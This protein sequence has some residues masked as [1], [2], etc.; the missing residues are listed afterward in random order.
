MT[1]S[2]VQVSV[3]V[4]FLDLTRF[5]AESLRYSDS[6]IADTLDVL[7]ERITEDVTFAGGTV[8]K[9]IGD[10]ALIVFAENMVDRGVKTCLDLKSTIDHLMA[11]RGW[12]SRLHV[13]AHFGTVIAGP[14]G[15]AGSK[16]YDVIGKTVNTAAMMQ[17]PGV[18]LS[19]AAFRKLSPEMRTYFKKH[20]PP[21]TYI[22][23]EDPHRVRSKQ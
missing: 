17:S 13:K 1:E 4:A 3:L 6:E 18:A 20:T 16:R 21:V 5:A 14:Y 2:R 19:V 12:N 7:Y 11:E 22:R 23:A 9:F 15:G 10:A 8:V